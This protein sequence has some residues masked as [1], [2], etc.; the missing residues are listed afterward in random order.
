LLLFEFG[1]A[2]EQGN[3]YVS[4]RYFWDNPNDYQEHR[5]PLTE[6]NHLKK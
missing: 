1:T 4:L 5:L 3:D 2:G 6:I